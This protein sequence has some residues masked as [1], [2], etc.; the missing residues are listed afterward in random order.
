MYRVA[1]CGS[2]FLRKCSGFWKEQQQNT[3]ASEVPELTHSLGC[4]RGGYFRGCVR[5][6][7]G[8]RL[9]DNGG[10]GDVWRGAESSTH[11]EVVLHKEN[12]EEKRKTGVLRLKGPL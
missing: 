9:G 1:P 2:T 10:G 7:L 6:N 8:S 4:G 11:E 12:R 3:R 5:K